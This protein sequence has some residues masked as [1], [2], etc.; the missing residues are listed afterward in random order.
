MRLTIDARY[1][2]QNFELSVPLAEGKQIKVSE[3]TSVKEIHKKF[4]EVHELA[5]GYASND[6][7]VEVINIRLTAIATLFEYSAKQARKMILPHPKLLANEKYILRMRM[8]QS[9]LLVLK[10]IL[11]QG[12]KFVVQRLLNN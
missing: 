8:N 7:S 3:L 2:G 11:F 12:K 1:T 9:L 4:C 6:D 5:Y 10:E